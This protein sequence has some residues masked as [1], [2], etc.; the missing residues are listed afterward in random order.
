ML[1]ERLPVVPDLAINVVA[2]PAD[3]RDAQ[4]HRQE[5][6]A[7]SFLRIG[8]AQHRDHHQAHKRAQDQPDRLHQPIEGTRHEARADSGQFQRDVDLLRRLDARFIDPLHRHSS[9]ALS[10]SVQ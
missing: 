7:D 3:K 1:A 8:H 5:Q 2:E 9:A 10:A 4:T 6:H